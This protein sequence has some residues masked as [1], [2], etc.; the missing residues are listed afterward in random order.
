MKHLYISLNNSVLKH[1]SGWGLYLGLLVSVLAPKNASAQPDLCND[2]NTNYFTAKLTDQTI[3]GDC[4]TRTLEIEVDKANKYALSHL[5]IEVP[6]GTVTSASN[7]QKWKMEINKTDPKS[8]LY[9]LKITNINGFGDKKKKQTFLVTYIVCGISACA[10]NQATAPFEVF[11]KASTCQ[12]KQT[13]SPQPSTPPIAELTG[14]I[15]PQHVPC[16]GQEN[17]SITVAATGGMRPYTYLWNNGATD[18]LV[19]NVP[20]GVY[21]VTVTDADS[22]QIILSAEVLQPSALFAS[23]KVTPSLCNTPT[24][25]IEI[26]VTEGTAPYTYLWDNG[27]TTYKSTDLPLGKHTV[28]VTDANGCTLTRSYYIVQ[29]TNLA[30]SLTAPALECH[31]QGLGTVAS[32]VTGGTA[33]YSYSWSNGAT[34]Q[35]LDQVSSGQYS[36]TVTDSEGCTATQ[37]A[38]VAIKPLM[39]NVSAQAP[40]CQDGHTGSAT[41]T[42]VNGTAPYTY[43]WSN[44]YTSPAI[45]GLEPG[46]Y[47][48]DITDANGCTTTKTATIPAAT[49]LSVKTDVTANS[50]NEGDNTVTVKLSATGGTAPLT[51]TVNGTPT[52]ATF[53]TEAPQTLRITVTDAGGCSLSTTTDI[54]Y[55]GTSMAT[56]VNTI[57]PSCFSTT[58][59]TTITVTGAA[60]PVNAVWPDGYTGLSRSGLEPGDYIVVVTDG[61]G[62]TSA[63]AIKIDQVALPTVQIE[64]P[65]VQEACGT[66]GN[67]LVAVSPTAVSSQWSIGSGSNDWTIESTNLLLM[68]YQS[69]TGSATI[70]ITVTDANGCQASDTI[71]VSCQTDNENPGNGGN[72]PDDDCTTEDNYWVK[73]V[74]RSTTCNGCYTYEITVYTDGKGE[75]EL[76]HFI[77]GIPNGTVK[78]VSLSRNWTVEKNIT[79]PKSGVYG[80][81]IDHINGFGQSGPDSFSVEYTVCSN[82][83]LFDQFTVVYKAATCQWTG[84]VNFT[85]SSPDDDEVESV[86]TYPNPFRNKCT[87]KV[88]PKKDC[89]VDFYISDLSGNRC[90]NL[91]NGQMKQ[92]VV[93]KL[94]FDGSN[95]NNG[96]YFYKMVTQSG[97]KQGKIM[98]R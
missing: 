77:I 49:S 95:K 2:C 98:K 97:T 73:A 25:I 63:V 81:K 86:D 92:G 18:S 70:S 28:V 21:S 35:N 43:N 90:A 10:N 13:I 78:S 84:T 58:G 24:G 23:A 19:S 69:G 60:Q 8:G 44:G 33:P 3:S 88:K 61:K 65:E 57:Q 4:L 83:Q 74:E 56:T 11:F 94:E 27:N 5:A 38:Y 64:Q 91:Y 29:N 68:T 30:V 52:D 22:T 20:A 85:P 31:Q 48:V 37:S 59:A 42:V 54:T 9:G 34:T 50:C 55:P 45:T 66:S 82:K 17:G 62:C 96:F 26:N 76:S 72:N 47:F 80:I 89:H 7:S 39:A 71:E 12:F 67:I 6:C 79:D 36:V 15:L 51:W 1:L 93:Y 41:V 87:F 75:H 16:N 14:T 32:A 40:N 46:I 53:V